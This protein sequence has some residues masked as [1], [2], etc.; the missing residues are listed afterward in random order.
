MSKNIRQILFRET[1]PGRFWSIFVDGE[2]V[3]D[4][5]RGDHMDISDDGLAS[6]WDALGV[7]VTFENHPDN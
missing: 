6:L 1:E 2:L 3:E 7:T 5:L 4:S